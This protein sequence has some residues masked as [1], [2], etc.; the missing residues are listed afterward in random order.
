MIFQLVDNKQPFLA[1]VEVAPQN[2]GDEKKHDHIAGCL[3]AYAF[4][5]SLMRGVDK[6]KGALHFKIGEERKENEI[7]L[8]ALYS[9]KYNAYRLGNSNIMAIY[10]DD[11]EQLIKRYLT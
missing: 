2:K 9:T 10:D 11:G 6:Y 5:L 8:M 7:K 4:K 3:I 1:Y